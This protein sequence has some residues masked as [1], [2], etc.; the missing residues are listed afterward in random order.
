MPEDQQ[1]I[2]NFSKLNTRYRNIQDKLEQLKVG[3]VL[4]IACCVLRYATLQQDKEALDDLSNELELT[5]EDEQVMCVLSPISEAG[6]WFIRCLRYKIGE[7]FVHLRLP[8]ALQRLEKDLAAVQSERSTLSASA[9]DCQTQ[10][11]ELKTVLYAK[12]G[13]AINLDE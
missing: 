3:I 10:M 8:E 1:R 5:D 12:F 6:D 9:E 11:R 2:C 4:L 7:A 13:S